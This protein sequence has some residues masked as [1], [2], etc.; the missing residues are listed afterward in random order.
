MVTA[1]SML[2]SAR[3]W[4]E[5]ALGDE[6]TALISTVEAHDIKVIAIDLPVRRFRAERPAVLGAAFQAHHTVTFMT[7]KPGHY[8][9][10]GRALCGSLEV[11][12]IGIPQRLI[13]AAGMASF[14]LNRPE[15]WRS[16]LPKVSASLT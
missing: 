8:L 13:D 1:L 14:Y 10:P 6:L 11:F 9:L 2:C 7:P 16:A 4:P 3:D 12:D 15:L 5:A